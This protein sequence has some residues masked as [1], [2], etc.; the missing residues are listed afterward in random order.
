MSLTLRLK[1]WRKKK[2][3]LLNLLTHYNRNLNNSK[4]M[5]NFTSKRDRLTM[6]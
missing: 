4:S 1:L 2:K 6:N 5:K 3:S